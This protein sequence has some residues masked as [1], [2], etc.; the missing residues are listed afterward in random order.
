VP[1]T[2][3]DGAA[4]LSREE[5]KKWEGWVGRPAGGLGLIRSKYSF[6]FGLAGFRAVGWAGLHRD[7]EEAALGWDLGVGTELVIYDSNN[8]WGP[9]G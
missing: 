9:F 6:S 4:A 3:A 5:E 2:S 8:F 7:P 1:P